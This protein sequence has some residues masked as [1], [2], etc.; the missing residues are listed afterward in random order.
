[1]RK[2]RIFCDL[3]KQEL[4]EKKDMKIHN[5]ELCLSIEVSE[6]NPFNNSDHRSSSITFKDI[7]LGCRQA[8]VE[9]IKEV[10][11]IRKVW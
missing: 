4:T 1:M 9:A 11:R 8:F 10:I 6:G 2:E 3:C 5:T 7:C